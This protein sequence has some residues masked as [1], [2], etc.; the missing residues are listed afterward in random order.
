LQL[1]ILVRARKDAK[2]V[3]AAARLFYP[4][5]DIRVEHLGGLRGEAL[6]SE[7]SSRASPFTIIL[8]PRHEAR[9]LEGARLPPLARVVAAPARDVRNLRLEQ[10][11]GLIAR[12][13]ALIR[14]SARWDGG[15][16]AYVLDS[17]SPPP[18]VEASP[19]ADNTILYGA[20][21]DWLSRLIGS[22]LGGHAL[23]YVAEGRVIVHH[24]GR[25]VAV[26][27]PDPEPPRLVEA[28][29]GEPGEAS[30]LEGLVEANRGVVEEVTRSLV[31]WLRSAAGR[32]ARVIVP[33]SGGKDSTAALILAVKAF[34]PERVVAVRVDTGVELP[35]MA[36]FAR[37]AAS[38]LG[39]ELVEVRAPLREAILSGRGLPRRGERW[40]T[41]IK[42]E[43][44]ARAV[45]RLATPSGGGAV[46]VVGDRDAESRARSMRPPARED[47]YHGLPTLAPLKL[48][49]GAHVALLA[50]S[51]GVGL[52][53]VYGE[54]FYRA[55]CYI[56]PYM[57]GWERSILRS[58]LRGAIEA[59]GPEA[60]A[61]LS[62]FLDGG[63]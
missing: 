10:I 48:L 30:G 2:A 41:G 1:R 19:D 31:E 63:N 23:L 12:G 7:A 17:H 59:E 6:A 34:G 27:D 38:L 21:L 22:R 16:G 44:L 20:G 57:R 49:G 5:F 32:V 15:L 55:G 8:L 42:L 45:R 50:L 35:G 9:L 51:S 3:E 37:R 39:V 36:E 58:R 56:C 33:W 18:G 26:V 46:V 52:A 43:A 11:A 29:A 53:R 40:C 14:L 24:A 28:E 4:G 54:G 61:L 25:L 13:R 47:H 60:R 62:A